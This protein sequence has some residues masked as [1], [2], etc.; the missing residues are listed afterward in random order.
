MNKS[1]EKIELF[2]AAELV[3]WARINAEND[4][5]RYGSFQCDW[6]KEMR[7]ASERYEK[8]K[9]AIQPPA[10]SEGMT[11]AEVDTIGAA[12]A[13]YIFNI[14]DE[15]DAFGGKAWRIEFKG[16]APGNEK[17]LGGLHEP[18]L[19]KTIASA[20]RNHPDIAHH[21]CAHTTTQPE[22]QDA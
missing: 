12:I 14:G 18:A 10:L 15:N 1:P 7:E 22:A 4:V 21:L 11:G 13:R 2:V 3:A 5:N 17:P 16:G 8:A 20:I 9:A 19:A 6:P